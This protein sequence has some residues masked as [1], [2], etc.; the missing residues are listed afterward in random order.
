MV[1]RSLEDVARVFSAYVARKRSLGLLD[2]DD[3][4]LFWRVVA[5]HDV[6]GKQLGSSY[7]HI[8]VDEFQDV[9]LLQLEVLTGLRRF[10]PR[11]TLVGDD[12]QAI[13]GFRGA[14]P[15]YLL[16]A[17]EYFADLTT[18]TLEVN[19]RSS[20]AI[21]DVANALA[22]DAPEGLLCRTA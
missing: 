16:H 14:S 6:L 10:D 2:F 13:Y 5:E 17:D 15:A 19:Y 3:L 8:L 7:D 22:A 4:L 21:L 12:A 1:R 20:A 18:I 9:N 11:V